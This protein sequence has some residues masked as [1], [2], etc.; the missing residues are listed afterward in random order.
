[1]EIYE[2]TGFMDALTLPTTSSVRRKRRCSIG[3]KSTPPIP[4]SSPTNKQPTPVSERQYQS[5]ALI[6]HCFVTSILNLPIFSFIEIHWSPL[7][8]TKT[9]RNLP[10]CRQKAPKKILKQ[11]MHQRPRTLTVCRPMLITDQYQ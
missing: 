9:L 4:T 11:W 7:K 1:M 3:H 8:V 10:K 2:S 6:I 5:P